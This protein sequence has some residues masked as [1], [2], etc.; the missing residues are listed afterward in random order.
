MTA[1]FCLKTNIFYNKTKNKSKKEC[2]KPL[3]RKSTSFCGRLFS[4]ALPIALQN[5]ITF[6]SGLADSIMVSRLGDG[7]VSG[8]YIGNQIGTILILFSGGIESALTVICSQYWGKSEK[9]PIK[10]TA[11]AA[12]KLS[13]CVGLILSVICVCFPEWA[14]SLFS[15]EPSSVEYGASYLRILAVSFP[16]FCFTMVFIAA[17]RAAEAPRLGLYISA[18]SLGVNI[19]LNYLLI[20]GKLGFPALGVVGA[21][22]ATLAARITETAVILIYILIFDKR[23]DLRLTDLLGLDIGL[24]LNY[25]KHGTPIIIAQLVWAVNTLA[26]T[27]IMGRLPG[28]GVTAGL[29][30]AVT[31]QGLAY[32]MINGMSNSLGIITGK[33]V[34]EDRT[35][36]IR[37]YGRRAELVFLLVGILTGGALFLFKKL[38][39][40][41]YGVS[42]AAKAHAA[43]FINVLSVSFIGTAYG[44]SCLNGLIKS[45]GDTDFVLKT[46]LFFV[47]LVVIPS[48][49]SAVR[50][51]LAPWVVFTC[52]KSDQILKCLVASVKLRRFD[53]I[54]NLTAKKRKTV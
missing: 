54:K 18:I 22:I 25:L 33:T 14:V 11:S 10:K 27:A 19:T 28:D 2:E 1:F 40:S 50:L 7:A 16:F 21:A 12:L 3:F 9:D 52:L 20:L 42:G 4:L 24:L 38:F 17:E 36:K 30:I 15:S 41:L 29:S 32:V 44:T 13:L 46:D 45:G 34:G 39:I 43:S 47:F 23:L 53:W 37:A 35:D 8:V 5:L 6:S 49:L 26:S 31:M 48:A 51:G